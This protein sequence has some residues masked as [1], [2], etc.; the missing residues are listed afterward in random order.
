MLVAGRYQLL[1]LAGRGGMSTV[2]RARDTRLERDVAIKLLSPVLAE[3]SSFV[4]RFKR[5]AQAAAALNHRNIVAVHDWGAHED[6]YF[7]AMEFVPG[8]TLKEV[9]NRRGARPEHEAIHIASEVASAL[10]AAHVRGVVHRDVK[11]HNILLDPDGNIKVADFGIARAVGASALT[12]TGTILGSAT[13]ASPEQI[14][15]ELVDARSDLYSLG[16]VLFELLAGRPPFS[17]DS[18][19]AIAWQHVH[20]SPPDLTALDPSI[21]FA[22]ALLVAKA[23]AKD[24]GDRFQTASEMHKVLASLAGGSVT[25]PV[26]A[27]LQTTQAMEALESTQGC[28]DSPR[29][30]V[31][32]DVRPFAP[33]KET[34]NRRL[35]MV[36]ALVALLAALPLGA[37]LVVATRA[38]R[39]ELA[40]PSPQATTPGSVL[41]AVDTPLATTASTAA[42]T[43]V[44]AAP[45]AVVSTAA[46]PTPAPRPSPAATLAPPPTQAAVPTQVPPNVGA[47]A[48]VQAVI[49]FYASIGNGQLDQAARLW[50]PRMQAQYPPATNLHGRFDQTRSMTVHSARIIAQA[51]DSATVAIELSE[52]TGNPAVTQRW[53]GTWQVVRS[54][55]GWLLDNP[56]LQPA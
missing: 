14:Q 52:V 18:A 49:A 56:S 6:T 10:E 8:S 24:A 54:S 3:D 26:P 4:E 20:E 16:A 23:L 39:S 5:E 12:D 42:P 11:P 31:L 45:P 40:L 37:A 15:R 19:V 41:G 21:S 53:A 48:P 17:G 35:P 2:Y 47:D 7:I 30:T 28:P 44:E 51:A 50:S 9:I 36:A 34:P 25:L 38:D 46:P 33:P 43:A 27:S 32:P 1:K 55:A 22:A 29:T 13:Y